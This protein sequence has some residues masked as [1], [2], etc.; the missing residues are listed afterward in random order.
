MRARAFVIAGV[1]AFVCGCAF[2]IPVRQVP[3]DQPILVAPVGTTVPNADGTQ[4]H[5]PDLPQPKAESFRPPANGW[6]TIAAIIS[7]LLALLFGG[8]GIMAVRSMGKLRTAARIAC[9]LVD[10]VAVADTD[11]QVVAAKKQAA[12]RQ[13]LYGVRTLTQQIR[14]VA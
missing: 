3:T 9:D 12:E 2:A 7:S 10:Q 6:A 14:G 11:E 1:V 8:G 5:N 13:D 4:T